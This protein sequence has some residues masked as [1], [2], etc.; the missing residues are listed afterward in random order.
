MF[1]KINGSYIN[2]N[3]IVNIIVIPAYD[4]D[5]RNLTTFMIHLSTGEKAM[6][7]EIPTLHLQIYLCSKMLKRQLR[8]K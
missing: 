5:N 6:R 7:F 8:S 2:T 1:I 3:H 4:Y